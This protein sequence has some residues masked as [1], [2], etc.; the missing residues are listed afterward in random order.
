[1]NTYLHLGELARFCKVPRHR[2][3]YAVR[4][5]GPEPIGVV[6]RTA[7][8]HISQVPLVQ[9]AISRVEKSHRGRPRRE[10]SR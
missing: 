8:W 4:V 3:E 9:A 7:F 5:R 2:A 10:E 1:M 6:G